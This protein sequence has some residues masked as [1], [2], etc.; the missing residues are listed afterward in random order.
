M[1]TECSF[2]SIYSFIL[3]VCLQPNGRSIEYNLRNERA[4]QPVRVVHELQEVRVHSLPGS[5]S[6]ECE[7]SRP[8]SA[9]WLRD[10]RPLGRADKRFEQTQSGCVHRLRVNEVTADDAG[11]YT[12]EAK[13]ASATSSAQ[14]LVEGTRTQH[15]HTCIPKHITTRLLCRTPLDAFLISCCSLIPSLYYCSEYEWPQFQH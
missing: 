4:E 1:I 3:S 6:F 13:N 5:A 7:L 12:L 8:V 2:V 14:L 9:T 11:D 15:T 10:G